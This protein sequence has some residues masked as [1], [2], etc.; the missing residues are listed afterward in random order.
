MCFDLD[1]MHDQSPDGTLIDLPFDSLMITNSVK[2][3][4][5]MDDIAIQKAQVMGR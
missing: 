4:L 2:D 3:D 5:V 1:S